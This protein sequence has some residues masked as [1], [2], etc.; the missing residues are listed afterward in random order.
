MDFALSIIG[1]VRGGPAKMAVIASSLMGMI[2]GSSIANVAGVGSF[3][4][5]LMKKRDIGRNS[6][7]EW[8][9]RAEWEPNHA[10]GHGFPDD[11]G[12]VLGHLAIHR[13]PVG[14]TGRTLLR[15]GD[16]LVQQ[17]SCIDLI[18]FFHAISPDGIDE[19]D[20]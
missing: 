12:G 9:R 2:T 14:E 4:I 10:S 6:P 11:P 1:T 17:P 16:P 18:H 3:T 20:I 13:H 15:T 19:A 7:P 5:P 8:N